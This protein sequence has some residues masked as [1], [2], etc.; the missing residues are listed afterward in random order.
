MDRVA[1]DLVTMLKMYGH[2]VALCSGNYP[3]EKTFEEFKSL[4]HVYVS[5][6]IFYKVKGGLIRSLLLS[7]PSI[8]KCLKDFRPDI[9]VGTGSEPAVFYAVPND[10]VKIQYIHFPTEFFMQIHSSLLHLLYR[11]PYWHYHYEQLSRIDAAVCNSNY[12]K[13]ITHLTWGKTAM[14][15]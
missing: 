11:M 3:A 8:K 9:F 6:P 14:H 2:S 15:A 5:S 7:K 4:E 1:A 10:K 12:T 13:E